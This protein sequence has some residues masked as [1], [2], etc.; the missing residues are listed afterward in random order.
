M[1]IVSI[2]QFCRRPG[3]PS[4]PTL[5]KIIDSHPDFP[6]VERGHQGLRWKIDTEAAERFLQS[7]REPARMD[8]ERRR[9]LIKELG[10]EFVGGDDV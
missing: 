6:V 2:T 7:L 9:Q 5:R 4:L 1:T 10:L 8:P 3:A